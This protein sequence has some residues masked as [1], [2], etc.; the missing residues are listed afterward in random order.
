MMERARKAQA[1]MDG[2]WGLAAIAAAGRRGFGFRRGRRGGR[3]FFGSRQV[4]NDTEALEAER[5]WLKRRLSVVEDA[6]NEEK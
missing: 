1:R 3:G 6:L 5:S 2:A 4:L